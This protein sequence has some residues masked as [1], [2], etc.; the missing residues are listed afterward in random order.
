MLYREYENMS[1][2]GMLERTAQK[3]GEK[4]AISFNEDGTPQTKTYAELFYDVRVLGKYLEDNGLK[5]K[6]VVV[7]SRNTYAQLVSMFAVMAMGAV[8]AILN[9]DLPEDDI[10]SAFA[11]IEPAMVIYDSEDADF[12]HAFRRAV[13]LLHTGRKLLW[14]Y[15]CRRDTFK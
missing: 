8:A 11:R 6:Y 5:G 4:P 7:D 13:P 15:K 2:Y 1:F 14:A 9:F 12:V 3:Y 10:R